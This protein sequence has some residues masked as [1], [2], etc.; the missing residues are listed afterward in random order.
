M[1]PDN[2]L[3]TNLE[4]RAKELRNGKKGDSQTISET[5]ADLVDLQV[6]MARQGVVTTEECRAKHQ[7][8]KKPL[9]DKA[10]ILAALPGIMFK[11]NIQQNKD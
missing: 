8:L 2:P 6:Y 5:L 10:S 11:N 3:L 1:D 4:R 9:F 7:K